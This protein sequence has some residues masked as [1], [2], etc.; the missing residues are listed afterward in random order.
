[1]KKYLFYDNIVVHGGVGHILA[2]YSAGLK[3][4]QEKQLEFL[5]CMLKPLH[6]PHD[7]FVEKHLGLE[8]CEERRKQLLA[9][10][11]EQIEHIVF[12][13]PCP[14]DSNFSSTYSYFREKYFSRTSKSFSLWTDNS[15]GKRIAI[16]IRRGDLVSPRCPREKNR[17]RILPDS[18]FLQA[19]KNLV[20]ENSLKDP[21]IYIFTDGEE[22]SQPPVYINEKAQ[23]VDLHEI[24][25][26]FNINIHFA[27][28]H[29]SESL[30]IGKSFF[31]AFD[32]MAEADFFIVGIS[33]MYETAT[34]FSKAS[35][36]YPPHWQGYID[37]PE[38]VYSI[39]PDIE[40]E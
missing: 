23:R 9:T 36:I 24:F 8:I 7:N 5:P 1:M 4:A 3:M 28:N 25:K 40:N 22:F 14:T 33:G 20:S 31:E 34:M 6:L 29:G 2:C 11:P 18:Y 27:G 12:K 15:K 35:L 16:G 30:G 39:G 38:K 21:E 32:S 17:W 37:Y 26:G 13:K 10:V 19:L